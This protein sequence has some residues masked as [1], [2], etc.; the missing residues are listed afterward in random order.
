MRRLQ[1]DGDQPFLFA[2]QP[3]D[4]RVIDDIL[5]RLQI[6]RPVAEAAG[7]V[8]RAWVDDV[9]GLLALLAG[10]DAIVATRF[11]GTVLAL[12]TN[13]PVLAICYHRK[14]RDLMHAF[15]LD[16]HAVEFEAASYPALQQGLAR[17]FDQAAEIRRREAACVEDY[18][19]LLAEQL[20]AVVAL[21]DPQAR[22]VLAEGGVT[23]PQM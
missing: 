22:R 2:T 12:A 10:A 15:G 13:R 16:E 11:H 19:R 5:E 14:T 21:A 1:A 20:D 18:R 7:L 17:V 3:A 8:L 4:E 9:D 6:E 23:W